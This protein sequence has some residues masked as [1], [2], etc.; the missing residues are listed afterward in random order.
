[1]G[2]VLIIF[3]RKV[4]LWG[5]YWPLNYFSRALLNLL[6]E[7]LCLS[8]LMTKFWVIIFLI[9]KVAKLVETQKFY[10]NR[11]DHSFLHQCWYCHFLLWWIFRKLAFYHF[12]GGFLMKKLLESCSTTYQKMFPKDV[13]SFS[14]K[15]EN[16]SKWGC[17]WGGRNGMKKLYE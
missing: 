2:G 12:F 3:C 1:M 13:F 11:L 17:L 8:T 9:I 15:S 6:V 16:P 10:H 4:P 14:N 5:P 7:T